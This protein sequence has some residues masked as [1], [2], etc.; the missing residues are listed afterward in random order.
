MRKDMS[1]V[2]TERPRV[3]GK[4]VRK[5]RTPRD[6]GDLPTKQGMKRPY[7]HDTKNFSDVLGPIKGFLKKAVGRP[8]NDVYSEICENIDKSNRVQAHILEHVWQYVHRNVVIKDNK[9][10]DRRTFYGGKLYELS[11]NDTYICPKTGIL[12]KYKRKEAAKPKKDYKRMEFE[13]SLK[14]LSS[15][16][17]FTWVDESGTYKFYKDK[18]D[19]WTI[20]NKATKHHAEQDWKEAGYEQVAGFFRRYPKFTRSS[21]QYWKH[22]YGLFLAYKA[23]KEKPLF[24]PGDKVAVEDDKGQWALGSVNGLNKAGEIIYSYAVTMDDGRIISVRPRSG[25][26]IRKYKVKKKST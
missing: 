18:K 12:K 23:A 11:N 7:G 21:H 5:G 15:S 10:F 9:I 25:P 13:S 1:K 2:I 4:G 17:S 14:S 22:Y 26:K 6:L 8:W 16:K 20:R 24:L 3:G 19:E